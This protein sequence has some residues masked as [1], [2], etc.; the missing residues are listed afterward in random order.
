MERAS[1]KIPSE[2]KNIR[3]VSARIMEGLAQYELGEDSL[4]DIRLCIEEAVRNAI[5]HGNRL[6]KKLRVK[7]DYW[8]DDEKLNVEV[9]DEGLGFDPLKIPDPKKNSNM[10]KESGRGVFLIKRLMDKVDFNQKGNK[11][12]MEKRL[13]Q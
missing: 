10:L 7:I 1:I 6:N 12:R 5:V 8:V 3:K 11:I 9:E 4:F 2:I 13:W